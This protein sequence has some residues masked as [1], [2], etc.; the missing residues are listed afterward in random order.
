MLLNCVRPQKRLSFDLIMHPYT[1]CYYLAFVLSGCLSMLPMIRIDS[2]YGTCL[3]KQLS[4][5]CKF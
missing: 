2:I 5:N 3:D 4:I 1:F